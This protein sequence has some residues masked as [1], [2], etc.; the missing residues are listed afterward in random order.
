MNMGDVVV[1][2]NRH[3]LQIIRNMYEQGEISLENYASCL[4]RAKERV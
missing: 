4:R 1:V 3:F 2:Q